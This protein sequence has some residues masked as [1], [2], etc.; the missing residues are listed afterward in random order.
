VHIFS[1]E[2]RAF[3]A[4]ERLWGSADRIAIADPAPPHAPSPAKGLGTGD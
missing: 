1:P 4:L 2:S 3:Y